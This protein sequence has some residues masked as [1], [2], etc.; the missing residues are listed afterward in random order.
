MAYWK[1]SPEVSEGA[2][3]F[4]DVQQWMARAATAATSVMMA[5]KAMVGAAAGRW[6]RRAARSSGAPRAANR[7]RHKTS[8]LPHNTQPDTL[9]RGVSDTHVET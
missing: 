5:T 2:K 1:L 4:V 7:A 3:R 9:G 6:I 8:A